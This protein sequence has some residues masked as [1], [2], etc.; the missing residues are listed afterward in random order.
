MQT[1]GIHYFLGDCF[2]FILLI[3]LVLI[4]C[5]YRFILNFNG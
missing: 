2:L 1:G 4:V 3:A 5:F